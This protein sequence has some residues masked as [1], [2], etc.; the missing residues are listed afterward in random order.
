MA[1]SPPRSS[2]PYRLN[3]IEF[4]PNQIE[5]HI[6]IIPRSFSHCLIRLLV[7]FNN[8]ILNKYVN[9]EFWGELELLKFYSGGELGGSEFAMGPDL[10]HSLQVHVHQCSR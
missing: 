3:L 1:S 8:S 2:P 4:V 7:A 10:I 5:S 9:T 6:E